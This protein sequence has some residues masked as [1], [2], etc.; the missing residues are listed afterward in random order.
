VRLPPRRAGLFFAA[1]P[2]RA[3]AAV[4]AT[5]ASGRITESNAQSPHISRAARKGDSAPREGTR[6]TGSSPQRL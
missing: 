2:P 5:A 4:R 1:R 6:P 3:G